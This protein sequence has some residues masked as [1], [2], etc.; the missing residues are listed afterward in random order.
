M[1]L[2][3]PIVNF[4]AMMAIKGIEVKSREDLIEV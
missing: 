2:Y 4:G 1:D 3:Q